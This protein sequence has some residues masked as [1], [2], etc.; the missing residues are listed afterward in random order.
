MWGVTKYLLDD[1]VYHYEYLV[2]NLH[3]SQNIFHKLFL[4]LLIFLDQINYVILV[5][6]KNY[7]TLIKLHHYECHT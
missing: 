1:S 6:H 2:E 4:S 7:D 5:R 3:S